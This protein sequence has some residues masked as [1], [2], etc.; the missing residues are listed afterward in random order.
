M[1]GRIVPLITNEIYHVFNRGANRQPT[2]TTKRELT[3]ALESIKF[4]RFKKLPVRLSRFLTLGN[5]KRTELLRVLNAGDTNIDIFCWCF[6]PNHFHLLIKQNMDGGISKFLSNFQNSYT[7][8]FNTRHQR[9]GTL[10]LNQF[11]AVR[12]ETDEQLIHVSRY[13]HLNPYASH[14]IKDIDRLEY[15]RWSSFSEYISKGDG[16]VN[17]SLLLGFFKNAESY[18]TFVFDQA[19]YQRTLKEI[20]HLALE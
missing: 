5:E 17:K 14:V 3:R 20:E 16:F 1:P 6:M 7:R 13:I 4:Y 8:Y 2:F 18:K 9:D 10:F 15:Y 11:K 19:D 12:I